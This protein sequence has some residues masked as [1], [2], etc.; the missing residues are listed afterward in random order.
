MKMTFLGTFDVYSLQIK[1]GSDQVIF[2]TTNPHVSNLE[3]NNGQISTSSP[4]NIDKVVIND[5]VTFIGSNYITKDV[6]FKIPSGSVNFQNTIFNVTQSAAVSTT[7]NWQLLSS[8]LSISQPATLTISSSALTI[9]GQ[10]AE[11]F[12]NF[13]IVSIQ[14]GASLSVSQIKTAYAG[15]YSLYGTLTLSGAENTQFRTKSLELL[16]TQAQ[17]LVNG[18]VFRID[19]IHVEDKDELMVISNGVSFNAGTNIVNFVSS[20]SSNIQVKVISSG[21]IPTVVPHKTVTVVPIHTQTKLP[22]P[23]HSTVTPQIV[24]VVSVEYKSNVGVIIGVLI[25]GL[26][27]GAVV[28]AIIAVVVLRRRYYSQDDRTLL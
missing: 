19:S 18:A 26:V 27:F 15:D 10:K 6:E 14:Q 3:M 28:S 20:E 21:P 25:A 12:D 23:I 24:K 16:S 17:L 11:F 5:V 13:G 4:F 7:H 1:S 9:N 8:T 2:S 22:P